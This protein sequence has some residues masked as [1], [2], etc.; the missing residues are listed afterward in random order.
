[1]DA[2]LALPGQH[3]TDDGEVPVHER[4]QYPSLWFDDGNVILATATMLYRV[5]RGVL[6]LNS[7]VFREMFS[8]PQSHD[9]GVPSAAGE[10]LDGVPIV[11]I[12]DD[13]AVFRLLLKV[14]Y[15]RKC[16]VRYDG[17]IVSDEISLPT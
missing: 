15:D 10:N 16:V 2:N 13:D 11:R 8:L 5:H 4:A 3:L 6:S 9:E 14:F 7:P 1:M 17:N 12:H